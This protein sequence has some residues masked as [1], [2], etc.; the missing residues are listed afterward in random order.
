M[1]GADASPS[2]AAFSCCMARAPP[3]DSHHELIDV[4]GGIYSDLAP[5]VGL[6]LPLLY[7]ARCVVTQQLSQTMDTL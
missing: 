6:E 1:H 5:K 3:S 4:V 2:V 7:A